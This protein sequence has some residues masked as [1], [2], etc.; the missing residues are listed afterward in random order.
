MS[1][2]S[3]RQSP[4]LDRDDQR[5]EDGERSRLGR[6]RRTLRRR[7]ARRWLEW[8]P[9]GVAAVLTIIFLMAISDGIIRHLQK[10]EVVELKLNPNWE[11]NKRLTRLSDEVDPTW[12]QIEGYP[13]DDDMLKKLPDVH[14]DLETLQLDEG[15]I[16]DAGTIALPQLER[17][18]HL[19]LRH[20]P[21]GDE[22]IKVISQCEN[23]RIINLPHA[24]CTAEGVKHLRNLPHLRNLRLGSSEAGTELGRV[25]AE[26]KSL[27][28]IHL[29]DIAITDEGLKQIATLPHLES[30][31]LEQPAITEAGWIWLFENHPEIHVHV[32]QL[33]QHHDLDPKRHQ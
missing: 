19:R 12:L 22:G 10:P 18:T 5:S 32:N 11:W 8:M 20:S 25:I 3:D 31:Y 21:I 23:L 14:P 27:R 7:S 6:L 17:L 13:V 29:I 1:A 16:T 33:D 24:A 2:S 26:L 28:A 15:E 9:Y 4:D 30:L